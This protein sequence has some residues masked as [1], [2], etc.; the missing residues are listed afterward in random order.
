MKRIGALT[1]SAAIMI[2]FSVFHGV[3]YANSFNIEKETNK[4]SL[5]TTVEATI[6]PTPAVTATP[7]PALDTTP[8]ESQITSS[9]EADTT[10]VVDEHPL[11][12]MMSLIEEERE[13]FTEDDIVMMAQLIH[14]EA[15]GVKPLYC[16]A[17]VAWT[18]LNRMD[19]GFS[20]ACTTI[21]GTIKQPGQ[22]AWYAG[23]SYT[24]LDYEIAK[25]VLTR[26]AWEQITGETNE[27]RVLPSKYVYFWGDG[28]QNYFNDGTDSYWNFS[29]NYDPYEDWE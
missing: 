21:E 2:I 20:S 17:A 15:G 1:L 3:C 9:S 28:Y 26:W 12:S 6:S 7:T 19:N 11:D 27:G 29:V 16:R 25:D 5:E 14:V 24:D 8:A 18:V 4:E 13:Y 23:A 22:F 10:P